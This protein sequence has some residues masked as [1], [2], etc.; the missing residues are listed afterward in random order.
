M[1]SACS[2]K[3]RKKEMANRKRN[4]QLL[5][6][7]TEKEKEQ[8]QEN[9]ERSNLGSV[10]NYARQMLLSGKVVSVDYSAIEELTVALNR[11]G[12]NINQ[13]ARRANE[14]RSIDPE[15]VNEVKRLEK[16]I[17]RLQNSTLSKL[18]LLSR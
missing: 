18:G 15:S 14:V 1:P 16:E 12:N 6:M 11:I 4:K 5:L 9:A 7:L 8:I 2:E 3:A 13:I 10:S 17:W